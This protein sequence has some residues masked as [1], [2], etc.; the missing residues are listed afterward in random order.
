MLAA[1]AGLVSANWR[2]TAL[3]TTW[4]AANPAAAITRIARPI[5]A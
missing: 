3:R 4:T 5:S 1:R 2:T